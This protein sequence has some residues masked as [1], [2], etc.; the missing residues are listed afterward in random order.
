MAASVYYI[1]YTNG[2]DTAPGTNTSWGMREPATSH[3]HAEAGSDNTTTVCATSLVGSADDAYNG[4]FI[5]NRTRG[6]G[7]YITD[8][9]HDTHTLTHGSIAGNVTTDEFYIINAWKTTSKA[10]T[11]CAVGDICYIRAGLTDTLAAIV[12]FTNDGTLTSRISLIGTGTGTA[13]LETTDETATEM[14]HDA[15]TTRPI[16]DGNNGAFYLQLMDDDYWSFTNL[17]CRNVNSNTYGNIYIMTS[18]FTYITNCIFRDAANASGMNTKCNGICLYTLFNSCQFKNSNK[19][20]FMFGS[21]LGVGYFIFNNCTFDSGALGTETGILMGN[22]YLDGNLLLNNCKFGTTSA[23]SSYDISATL[24]NGRVIAKDCVWNTANSISFTADYNHKKACFQS[25]ND[26]GVYGA[27][28]TIVYS[29]TITKDAG[30]VRDGGATSS[31]KLMPTS[32]TST[33]YPLSVNWDVFDPDFRIWAAASPQTISIYIRSVTTWGGVYP[34]AA[35]LWT[36]TEYVTSDTT[37]A[38]TRTTALS[39][40]VLSDGTT[41]VGFTCG[42]FTPHVA[43]WVNIKVKLA[44]YTASNGIYVDIKPVIS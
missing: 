32:N 13:T 5:W 27:H 6:A 20:N 34:T 4:S 1:D 15:S 40:Q 16:I 23:H 41:W 21:S 19:Y 12:N 35:E 36:E 28:T 14:W 25:E 8:Y 17:D 7:A 37:G 43:G 44:K 10:A 29:G 2:T 30:V 24:D 22:Y 18:H 11:T 31:A 26:D 39:T 9:V 33:I 42:E 38:I 3:Y